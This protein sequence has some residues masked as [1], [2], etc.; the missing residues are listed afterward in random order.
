MSKQILTS[1]LLLLFFFWLGSSVLATEVPRII[2]FTKQQY[3]AHNQNWSLSQDQHHCI[4]VGNSKGLL[5]FD[6]IHWKTLPLPNNEIVRAVASDNQGRIFVGG[7]TTVGYWEKDLWGTWH[8]TSLSEKIADFGKEEIWHFLS[9]EAGMLFQSFARMY[10]FDGEQIEQIHLPGNIMFARQINDRIIIPVIQSGLFEYF[11]DG[12][13]ELVPG[14]AIT[15]LLPSC[16][17]RIIPGSLALKRT[18]FSFIKT[19]GLHP[20]KQKS[21][22]N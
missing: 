17:V 4:F 10:R 12:S 15:A 13:V 22:L 21:T 8:Y 14:S 18:V 9:T 2:N 1:F 19:A 3:Q 16:P 11:P 20:G 7:F 5:V 6:G